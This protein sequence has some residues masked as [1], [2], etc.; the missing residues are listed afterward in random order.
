MLILP[1]KHAIF[2][3]VPKTG[4]MALSQYIERSVRPSGVAGLEVE[5]LNEWHATLEEV[6]PFVPFSVYDVWSFAVVR[7]PFDRLVSYCAGHDPHFQVDARQSIAAA[8]ARVLRGEGNRWLAPQSEVTAG[9]KSLYRYEDFATAVP[10]ILDRLEIPVPEQFP[11]VNESER[12]PY[13]AYF[14]GNLKA[15]LE[16]AY[17]EDLKTFGYRF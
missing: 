15:M 6:A 3:A 7:N 4:S 8:L 14:D 12:G 16:S 10:A 5:S 11:T 1:E 13:R 2:V 9:V 17:A